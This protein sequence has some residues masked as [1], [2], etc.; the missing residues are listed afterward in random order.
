MA[1]TKVS[2]GLL[3]T[4]IVDN[5]NATAITIDSSENVGIGMT[6]ASTV[7]L[8]IKEAD[9][10]TDLILGLTAGTGGRVQIRSVAQSDGTSSVLSF[11]TMTGSSTSEAMRIDA[12]GNLL[13]GKTSADNT[14]QGVRIYSTGRQSIVSEA[15]TALIINRRTS[16][17]TIVDFRKDGTTIG[18]IGVVATNNLFIN[19]DTIGLAIG[20]DN[21]YPA[22]SSGAS[23]DGAT[24]L[25]DAVARWKDLY[26]SG[27]AFLGGTTSANF[28]DDYEEG[29]WTPAYTA[30]GTNP[31]SVTY[32]IQVGRYI[33][34][35]HQVVAQ[36][37]LRTD[38]S[39]TQGSGALYLSGLPFNSKSVSQLFGGAVIHYTQNWADNNAPSRAYQNANESRVV[40]VKYDSDDP[41]QEGSTSVDAGSLAT[42]SNSNDVICTII[43]SSA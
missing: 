38:G 42:G 10:S 18:K 43:Y 36:C 8:D 41:R 5:S 3:S 21:V 7:V 34:I 39:L 6:P 1:L 17:G 32:N 25:G 4:G 35:G 20:D 27:G 12:S 26:L 23:T 14:T 22:N 37:R 33:K 24:D 30:T 11:L 31:S 13:V 19:G 29:T 40:L 2:R 9:A 15:D 16:E 28:L